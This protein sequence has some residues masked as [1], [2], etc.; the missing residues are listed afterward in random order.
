M[1]VTLFFDLPFLIN[2]LME[3]DLVVL[4]IPC[5]VW[6]QLRHGLPHPIPLQLDCV[7]LLFPGHLSLE[8]VEGCIYVLPFSLTSSPFSSLLESCFQ[9][10]VPGDH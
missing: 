4:C 5:Q 10:L 7:P 8:R 1:G 9:F 6:L 3:V 2:I